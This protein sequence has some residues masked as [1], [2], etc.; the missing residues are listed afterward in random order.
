[1]MRPV[2]WRHVSSW[3]C[4][5]CGECCRRYNINIT[6]REYLRITRLYGMSVAEP[7]LAECY[8]KRREDGR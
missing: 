8:L 5:T 1:M 3:T 6:L 2:P 7:G 4:I